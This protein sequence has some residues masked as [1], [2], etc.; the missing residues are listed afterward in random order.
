[1]ATLLI[2]GN[3]FAQIYGQTF[4]QT[5]LVDAEFANNGIILESYSATANMNGHTSV[6]QPDGKMI[7]AGGNGNNEVTLVRYNTE[8]YTDNGFGTNGKVVITAPAGNTLGGANASLTVQTDGKIIY[9]SNANGKIAL[10][11]LKANGTL[12]STFGTAGLS[13]TQLGP[14]W[15]SNI[16]KVIVKPDG[17]ILIGG[18]GT[19]NITSPYFE[20]VQFLSNGT[21][22]PSFGTGG[23]FHYSAGPSGSCYSIALMPN[24][25]VIVGGIRFPIG[26]MAAEIGRA[27]V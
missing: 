23:I 12:D 16:G 13:Y 10:A 8:G 7:M 1:M 11:K 19:Y 6:L 22:D 5:G 25:H 15:Y 21:L 26:V 4:G 27:H 9:A 3:T 17:K 2:G 14:L 24:D 20:V 18:T